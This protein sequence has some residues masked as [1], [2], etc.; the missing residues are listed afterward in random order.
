MFCAVTGK[1]K[2]IW[3]REDGAGK[4]SFKDEKMDSSKTLYWKT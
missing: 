1:M 3:R 2:E 4:G